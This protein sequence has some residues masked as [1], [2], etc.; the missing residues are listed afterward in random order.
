[1]ALLRDQDQGSF[2]LVSDFSPEG[3]QPQAIEKLLKGLDAKRRDQVLLGVTGSG[4]TFTMANVIARV[5]RPTLVMAPNKTLAAQL[6]N[7]FRELFPENAVRYFVSYYDYY[8]PEAYVP[9]SDTYIEKDA[10]INDEIDKLRHS[11]TKALLERRDTLI[12]ASVSC[13]YGLGSPEAYFDLMV[14]LEVGMTINRDQMLRKLVD[15]QY[16]RS[17]YDFHRGT[18]RVRGDVVEIFPA[19]EDRSAL[20]IGFFDETIESISEID[21]IRGK[22]LRR[23]DKATVYPASHYVTDRERMKQAVAG[24]RDELQERLNELRDQRKLLEAQRLEQRTLYDLELLGE[25]GFCPGIENYSRHL[26]GRKP[27]EPPPTLFSYFPKDFLLVID[28]SHV[29]VPQIGG[30]YRGDRSRKETLVDFGFRLPSALDNRPLNFEE[31]ESLVN[32]AIYVSATPAAYELSKSRG[33]VVEQVIR[34]TGLMDPAIIVRPARSQVDDLLEEIRKR[35][36]RKE[37]VLVTTLTKRMA[38]DLTEYYQDLNVKVRYLHSDIETIERVE[39][40]RQLRMGQFDVL[41]GINLLREG[42][43]LPE[44]SL[45]AILDADKEGFLRSDR[46]LIQTIGRAARNVFGTVIMYADS[47]TD[48]MKRAID[49]TERRRKLQAAFN[50]KHGIT[51]QSIVK[52]LGSPLIKIYDADYVDVPLAAEGSAKYGTADLPRMIR[53]LQKEMKEAAQRLEFENAAQLRDRIR[54]LQEQ[55]LALREADIERGPAG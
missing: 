6:Y 46:S 34:P 19:Y 24:I 8:Q 50:K 1:M 5:N 33:A 10:S 35:V 23:L 9:S 4:K 51:P 26:T 22:M 17:D 25:M 11:A 30:M 41:V 29:T 18:F 39:I 27:G 15:I 13:I 31:F 21:A 48:S 36:E 47:V 12:V 45:V 3:D 28:E 16:E 2:R 42:L 44:V 7:E 52:S 55:E 14:Y 20:R 32:Q 38:E 49:E 40:I 53:K 43:D 37:R 54:E